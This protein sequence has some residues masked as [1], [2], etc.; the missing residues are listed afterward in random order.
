MSDDTPTWIDRIARLCTPERVRRY[1]ATIAV[2]FFGVWLFSFIGMRQ[3]PIMDRWGKFLGSDFMAFYTGA[4]FWL[5]GSLA[6]LYDFDAQRSFQL[7]QLT[8]AT[9]NEL[10]PFINPPFAVL[11]YAPFAAL[12]SYVS[13]LIAWWVAGVT[14]LLGALI[15]IRRATPGLRDWSLGRM[16]AVVLCFPPTLVWIAY[17]QASSLI[18]IIWAVTLW[19][20]TR[21]REFLAGLTLGLLAF[22]PQLALGLAIPLIAA[23]RWRALA[24]GA[25][26]LA[27]WGVVVWALF[28]EQQLEWLGLVGELRQMLRSPGYPGWG[29]H[30]LYGFWNLAVYPLSETAADAL[31]TITSS[32][33]GVSGL[34]WWSRAKWD[35]TDDAWWVRIAIT[36]ALATLLGVQFFWYDLLLWMFPF[37][38]VCGVARRRFT[39][40]RYLDDGPIL[41]WSALIFI[42]TFV[43][44]PLLQGL[45]AWMKSAGLPPVGL[46]LTT[47]LL[48]AWCWTVW[49]KLGAA[50]TNDQSSR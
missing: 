5:D 34:I 47:P 4:R 22:K 30:S 35:L 45:L 24:G 21:E 26:A 37:L 49:K 43:W 13:A 1:P 12:G 16:S 14:W 41:G 32:A 20:L 36:S 50:P 17:A 46:Q 23:R 25:C 19:L 7:A 38:I 8:D 33:L 48:L 28:A 3:D 10:A 44:G 9:T 11:I 18:L 27:I 15:L 42:T 40:A 2:V 6:Q 31:T 39:H 29:V